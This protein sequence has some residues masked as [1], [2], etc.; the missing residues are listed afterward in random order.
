[1]D[2]NRN[3]IIEGSNKQFSTIGGL[4]ACGLAPKFGSTH[5]MRHSM[6]AITRNVT[7]SLDFTQAVTGHKNLSR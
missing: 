2:N 5:M 7:G 6:A 3:S 1:M 4:K